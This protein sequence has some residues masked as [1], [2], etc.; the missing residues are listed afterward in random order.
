MHISGGGILCR[1]GSY[2]L[3]TNLVLIEAWQEE[4]WNTGTKFYS[5][6]IAIESDRAR[7]ILQ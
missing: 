7:L 6:M 1:E 5:V 2:L 3:S 4:S